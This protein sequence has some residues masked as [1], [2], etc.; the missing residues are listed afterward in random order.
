MIAPLPPTP[1][2]LPL[3]TEFALDQSA[4]RSRWMQR[5]LTPALRW[6]LLSQ[7]E[8]AAELDITLGAGD[9]QLLSGYLPLVQ[10]KAKQ[11]IYQGLHLSHLE[12]QG[13]NIR[14]NLGQVVRGKPLQLLEEVYVQAQLFLN[15]TDL[16]ASLGS[17]LMRSALTDLLRIL[18]VQDRR[19]SG[20][21]LEQY[22][23]QEAELSLGH[24]EVSGVFGLQTAEN[25]PRSLTFRSGLTLEN[26]HTLCFQDFTWLEMDLPPRNIAIDLG[27]GVNLETLSIQPDGLACQG[28]IA[29]DPEAHLS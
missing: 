4:R 19:A 12:L 25:G 13:Q 6:W 24:G 15:A 1:E 18:E 2:T 10:V 5:V 14:V 20:M 26:A 9:R 16:Q 21:G 7:V 17:D 27:P 22:G 29:I 28:A 3:E 8:G 23:V 11:V